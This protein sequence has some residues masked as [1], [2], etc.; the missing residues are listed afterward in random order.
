[1]AL[2]ASQRTIAQESRPVRRGAPRGFAL[3]SLM[4]A[5]FLLSI[6]VMAVGAANVSRIKEQTSATMRARA[7]NIARSYLEELRA[8]DAWTITDEPG[9]RVSDDGTIASAGTA[10]FTR[11][12]G[13]QIDRPN[14]ITVAVEV[15]G[16]RL[17]APVR[18]T[19]QVY[20]G[21]TMTIR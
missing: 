15:H 21:G 14:L 12:V 2:I 9:T 3:I 16:P 5:L 6:G 19:T 13:V 7:L 10:A 17:I 18:L 20:R 11:S 1:M 4:V 8:R